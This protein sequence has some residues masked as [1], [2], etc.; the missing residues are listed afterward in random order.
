MYGRGDVCVFG[1]NVYEGLSLDYTT[2]ARCRLSYARTHTRG[3]GIYS[4]AEGLMPGSGW[5]VEGVSDK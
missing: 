2:A 4:S 1:V 5:G 3:L